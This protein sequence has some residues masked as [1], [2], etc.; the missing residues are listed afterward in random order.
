MAPF[1]PDSIPDVAEVREDLFARLERW[2][3]AI[4]AGLAAVVL[5]T[6]GIVAWT[7]S[8]QER[9][10]ELRADM[11]AIVEDYSNYEGPRRL[12]RF[13][14]GDSPAAR[15][16]A[17]AEAK[18]LEELRPRAAGT[19]VEP[20]LLLHLALRRQAALEDD[21]A[22][23]LF[24]ELGS[25]HPDSPVLRLPSEGADRA[26]LV[27]HLLAISKKRRDSAKE[28]RWIEPKPDPSVTALVETDLGAMKIA[29]YSAKDL[30]PRHAEAFL[31]TAKEG[32]F[33]G[34][35]LYRARRGDSIELG[36]GDRT[37]NDE[38]RDDAEDDA[39]V[40]IAPEDGTRV[41]VRHRR[42]MV[43]SVPLLTGD[44]R[45]RFAVVLAE[46]K[47]E[48]DGVRTPFGELADDESAGVADRL[49]AAMV[50]SEDAVYINRKERTDYPWTPSKPV[51][52]RRVSIWRDG[53][54]DAGHAW[55][56]SRVGTDA[57]EPGAERG[58]AEDDTPPAG[59][60][61]KK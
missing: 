49:G 24:E 9:I 19:D 3:V 26:S 46:T 29:F 8:R 28:R 40:A 12:F 35:R 48:F 25:R 61:E 52:V 6:L 23:A 51:L 45:D 13:V 55:D 59:G 32:G 41:F 14:S 50:Y 57:P 54:L 39:A 1:S 58:G 5:G 44:Q 37:R 2:R 34:T 18:R 31:R 53:A 16:A 15:E 17:L 56:T 60:D 33:N 43:T 38:P 30:A 36:G 11:L 22:V 4:L 21:A 42:R 27:D 10:D 7:S 20:W 47:P